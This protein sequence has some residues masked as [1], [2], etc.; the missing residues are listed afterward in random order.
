MR[1]R[2]IWILVLLILLVGFNLAVEKIELTH[3]VKFERK[4]GRNNVF[5]KF[6]DFFD[7]EN[8]FFYFLDRDFSVVFKVEQ[9]TGKLVKTISSKGQGPKELQTPVN[10]RVRNKKIFV[11]DKG[12]NGVKIFDTEGN[13]INE[14]KMDFVIGE[15]SIDVNDK[16]EIFL[17]RADRKN[18]SMV[19]VF[20]IDGKKLRSL[21]PLK[22][23]KDITKYDKS[24]YYTIRLD[25]DSSIYVLYYMDRKLQ[26]YDKYGKLLWERLIKNKLLDQFPNDG[27]VKR[28][29]GTVYVNQR[30]IFGINVTPAGNVIVAHAG[31][32]CMFSIDGKLINLL[33]T[34]NETWSLFQFK[35]F[36][37]K[38]MN[39][40]GFG[41]NVYIYKFKED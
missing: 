12:F 26:K 34:P 21:I 31:G 37:D 15:R 10:F 27:K 35:V 25:K 28:G 20:D 6:C 16:E 1:S 9:N 36:D 5:L 8:G 29:K 18:N 30:R 11:L 38:L 32:G 33:T 17:G 3:P 13:T 4:L 39:I 14:F 19:Q 40:S 2:K 7:V 41:Q 23:G 24:W 22:G